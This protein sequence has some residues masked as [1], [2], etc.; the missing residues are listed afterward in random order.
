MRTYLISL[1]AALGLVGLIAASVAGTSGGGGSSGGGTSA[2]TGSGGGGS[3]HGGGGGGGGAHGAGGGHG[4]GSSHGGYVGGGYGDRAGS[5]TRQGTHGSYHLVGYQSAALGRGGAT[6]QNAHIARSTLPIG[7]RTGSAA[8]ARRVTDRT[9][10]P[11]P[12]N[13]PKPPNCEAGGKGCPNTEIP[14]AFAIPTAFCP[15]IT[16][17]RRAPGC[18]GLQR[19]SPLRAH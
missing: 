4:G 12:P 8:A 11:R 7:P 1:A 18:P 2:A 6:P 3:A 10:S 9:V 15:P 5:Y 17:S 19:S 16:A 14:V 13:K